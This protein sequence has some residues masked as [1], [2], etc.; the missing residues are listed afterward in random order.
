MEQRARPQRM[1]K[2][3]KADVLYFQPTEEDLGQ[4]G[5]NTAKDSN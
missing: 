4:G 1:K 5:R 2:M 3:E